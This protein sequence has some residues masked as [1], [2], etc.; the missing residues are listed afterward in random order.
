MD[1]FKRYIKIQLQLFM[2]G[3][4]V[5]PFFLVLYFAA[6]PNRDLKWMYWWGLLITAADVLIALW[7]T[8]RQ[9]GSHTPARWPALRRSE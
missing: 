6:T 5:G 4:L 2:Y 1:N 7:I 3:G 8:G 9:A